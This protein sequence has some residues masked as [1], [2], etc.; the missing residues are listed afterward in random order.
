MLIIRGMSHLPRIYVPAAS[1][2]NEV[3]LNPAL[4]HHLSRVLRL[5]HDAPIRIFDG[6]GREFSGQLVEADNKL[7]ARTGDLS[8]EEPPPRLKIHLLIAMSRHTRMEWTLEK[9]VELGVSAIHP[10][11]SERSRVKLD[12]RRAERKLEH[13]QAIVRSATA[14]SERAWLPALHRPRSLTE[15]W[16]TPPCAHRLLLSPGAEA[17]LA[18]LDPPEREMAIL[19]GPESGFSSEELEQAQGAGW[20]TVRLGP[21]VLRAETAGP[22]AIAAAQA[23]WGDWRDGSR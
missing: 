19:A 15:I 1:T 21:H 16:E 8:R 7:R 3:T 22:A 18:D 10:L 12:A 11:F 6:K 5:G 14:Q 23:L 17:S 4:Q 2:D 13:W 20:W 9:A